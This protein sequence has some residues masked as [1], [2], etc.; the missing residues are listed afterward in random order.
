MKKHSGKKT[1]GS[2]E[3]KNISSGT[4]GSHEGKMS[5]GARRDSCGDA[6]FFT[7]Y[8]SSLMRF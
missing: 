3:E 4:S 2:H 1:G 8:N 5:G 6:C 7:V